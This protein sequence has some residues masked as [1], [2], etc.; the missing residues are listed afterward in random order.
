M[1][2]IGL[3]VVLVIGAGLMVRSFRE[4]QQVELGLDPENVLTLRLSLPG[5]DYPQT[6]DITAFYRLLPERVEALPGVLS[7]GPRPFCR[8]RTRSGTGASTSRGDR[9]R[10]TRDSSA[11][12][13]SSRPATSRPW[14]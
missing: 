12:C 6:M 5:A 3:S 13:R 14:G 10:R 11:M 8:W 9:H 4:L 7:V 1:A 2:E